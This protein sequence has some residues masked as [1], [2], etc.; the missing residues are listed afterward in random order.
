MR[1]TPSQASALEIV[2]HR[3]HGDLAR[4][5]ADAAADGHRRHVDLAALQPFGAAHVVGIA[6]TAAAAALL[7]AS[8]G[9]G[10]ATT[11]SCRNSSNTRAPAK[12]SSQ[13]SAVM[14]LASLRSGCAGE[15]EPQLVRPARTDGAM[16][17]VAG[18]VQPPAQFAD[19]LVEHATRRC[20]SRLLIRASTW[21]SGSGSSRAMTS[22]PSSMPSAVTIG[23][24]GQRLGGGFELGAER[25]GARSPAMGAAST[26]ASAS[27]A[28][29]IVRR[30]RAALQIV[31]EVVAM[32]RRDDRRSGCPR[33]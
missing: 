7:A 16:V 18:R 13:Q 14:T 10:R 32:Q 11:I 26:S 22:W 31:V 12:A 5:G 8:Q 17:D 3:V 23:R 33:R 27:G 2:A 19:L 6:S 4:H 1:G 24:I 30:D 9:S 25:G 15:V 20:R 29:R 28:R 21:R